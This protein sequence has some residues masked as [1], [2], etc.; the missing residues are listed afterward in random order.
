MYAVRRVD[1]TSSHV[2]IIAEQRKKPN[3]LLVR[4]IQYTAQPIGDKA[5]KWWTAEDTMDK[6]TAPRGD[7]QMRFEIIAAAC[8]GYGKHVR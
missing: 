5:L 2:H 4:N 7:E 8:G 1:H 3:V 6:Y